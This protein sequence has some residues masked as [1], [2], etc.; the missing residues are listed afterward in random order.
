MKLQFERY[1]IEIMLDGIDAVGCGRG[2]RASRRNLLFAADR[3]GRLAMDGK[4]KGSKI[5]GGAVHVDPS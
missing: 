5:S 4:A 3:I 1:L 2:S